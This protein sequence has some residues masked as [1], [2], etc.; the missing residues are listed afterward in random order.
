MHAAAVPLVAP[1]PVMASPE[2]S[3][4]VA[5]VTWQLQNNLCQLLLQLWD[6]HRQLALRDHLSTHD[7]PSIYT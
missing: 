7:R 3:K 4:P 6:H 2:P 1:E 5:A